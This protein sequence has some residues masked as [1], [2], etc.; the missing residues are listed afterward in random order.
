MSSPATDKPNAPAVNIR[1]LA[2]ALKSPHADPTLELWDRYS[3]AAND[4]PATAI[5]LTNPNLA[6][7]MVSSSPRPPRD[8]TASRETSSLRRT[9][10]CGVH[11]P[12]RRRIEKPKLGSQGSWGQRDLEAASKSS[13]VSALLETVT[14]SMQDLSQED[15]ATP[16]AE[17]PSPK[18]KNHT[19]SHTVKPPNLPTEQ[20]KPPENLDCFDDDFDDDLFMEIEKNITATQEVQAV[21]F[22]PRKP[23]QEQKQS[24]WLRPEILSTNTKRPNT[25]S[26]RDALGEL[27]GDIFEDAESMTETAAPSR[28]ESQK[29]SQPA[30][31][32]DEEFGDDFSDDLDYEAIEIAATQSTKKTTSSVV[33]VCTL[34]MT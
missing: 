6:Q 34:D 12:K 10:S 28:A 25:V 26:T 17:S 3:L 31:E 27:K 19:V 11:V 23:L 18:K 24:A 29:P 9:V 32:F 7:L 8:M 13:L 16:L 20:A 15:M 33:N 4:S 5:G 22:P 30:K 1:K 21:Q 2:R 14:S